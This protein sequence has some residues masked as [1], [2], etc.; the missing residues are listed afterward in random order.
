MDTDHL[1]EIRIVEKEEQGSVINN[2]FSYDP[3]EDA[4]KNSDA[5]YQIKRSL[6]VG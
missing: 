4:S 5:L 2:G 3:K 6:G 1:D